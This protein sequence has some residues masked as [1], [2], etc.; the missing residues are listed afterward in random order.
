LRLLVIS[1][2]KIINKENII[3]YLDKYLAE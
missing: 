2:S 1:P 3:N